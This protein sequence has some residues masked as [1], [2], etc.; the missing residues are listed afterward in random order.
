[1]AQLTGALQA[2]QA[3]SRAAEHPHQAR[4]AIRQMRVAWALAR[5]TPHTAPAEVLETLTGLFRDLGPCRDRD[6]MAD[7]LSESLGKGWQAMAQD[8]ADAHDPQSTADPRQA[9]ASAAEVRQA[10]DTLH[11]WLVHSPDDGLSDSRRWRKHLLKRLTRWHQR[12]LKDAARFDALDDEAVH[13]F[14]KRLKRLRYGLQFAR[15]SLPGEGIKRYLK[16]LTPLQTAL[17]DFNDAHTA[18]EHCRHWPA[19]PDQRTSLAWL[20]HRQ[21]QARAHSREALQAFLAQPLPLT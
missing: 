4:V 17:G 11:A 13:T 5:S 20:H 8:P 9:L 16:V 1:V 21:Q 6:V 12:L 3:G 2:L 7:L 19:S 10:M 15:S 18:L 14:R